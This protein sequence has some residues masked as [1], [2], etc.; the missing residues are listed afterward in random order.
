MMAGAID[1]ISAFI[2]GLPIRQEYLPTGILHFVFHAPWLHNAVRH[3]T[4]YLLKAAALD[5][6]A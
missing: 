3:C 5:V 2:T 1:V 4:C 6:Y